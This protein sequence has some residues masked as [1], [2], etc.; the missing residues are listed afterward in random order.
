MLAKHLKDQIDKLNEKVETIKKHIDYFC[1]PTHE[2]YPEITEYM[3]F[4][5]NDIGAQSQKCFIRIYIK[6]SKDLSNLKAYITDHEDVES[7]LC[8]TSFTKELYSDEFPDQDACTIQVLVNFKSTLFIA[9]FTSSLYV[10]SKDMLYHEINNIYSKEKAVIVM[11][12]S[13]KDR[14]FH[15][16]YYLYA[17]INNTAL[18]KVRLEDTCM[19]Y[20]DFYKCIWHWTYMD[21]EILLSEIY[22]VYD[23]LLPISCL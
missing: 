21:P 10:F 2:R 22:Y 19:S 8:F 14:I 17:C 23:V 6:S 11:P 4:Y 15:Y 20:S 5:A 16:K 7:V 1:E 9:K 18:Y 13:T 12:V 3:K